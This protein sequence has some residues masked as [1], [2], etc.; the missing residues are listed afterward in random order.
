MGSSSQD[1]MLLCSVTLSWQNCECVYVSLSSF[2]RGPYLWSFMD[3]LLYD[4]HF[5]C[6]LTWLF[7]HRPSGKLDFID[8]V[9]G[10]QADNEMVPVVEWYETFLN[11][12]LNLFQ[13]RNCEQTRQHQ[14]SVSILKSTWVTWDTRL[15][16]CKS[17]GGETPYPSHP[18]RIQREP[19]P[20]DQQCVS[21]VRME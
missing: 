11:T 14:T 21:M 7:F 13:L 12:L 9:V 6:L 10:N 16:H 15:E 5:L 2:L 18:V 8:H 1:S 17:L 19:F 4:C 20:S 3:G